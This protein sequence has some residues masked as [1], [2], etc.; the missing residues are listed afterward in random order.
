MPVEDDDDRRG[1]LADFGE[2]VTL[3]PSESPS[4]TITAVWDAVSAIDALAPGDAD[5]QR[6]PPSF[7][8]RTSDLG[9]LAQGDA[10]R[11][12][13]TGDAY[14]VAAVLPD[15]TGFSRVDLQDA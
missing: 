3:R 2:E 15:G 10:V 4:D 12:D 11:R 13:G 8:A 6:A 1:L 7:I 9:T 5:V 14:T